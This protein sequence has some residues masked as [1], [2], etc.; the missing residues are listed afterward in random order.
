M[1]VLL[2]GIIYEEV[3]TLSTNSFVDCGRSHEEDQRREATSLIGH[4][5]ADELS[6]RCFLCDATAVVLNAVALGA[7]A[8][9]HQQQQQAP[10]AAK[11]AA[12]PEILTESISFAR[13]G[14]NIAGH[15]ARP[16]GEGP[17]R[18]VLVIGGDVGISDA[19]RHVCEQLAQSG[20]VGLAV[21][22]FSRFPEAK[23]LATGRKIF[24]E[25]MSDAQIL[26]DLEGAVAFARGRPFVRGGGVATLGYCMGGRYGLLLAARSAAVAATVSYYGLLKLDEKDRSKNHPDAPMD[27]LEH[28]ET[29][30]LLR[31]A[32]HDDGIPVEQVK[33]CEQTLAAQDTPVELFLYETGHGFADFSRP[34]YDARSAALAWE[35][36]VAFLRRYLS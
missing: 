8:R 20:F 3:R 24:A 7:A 28:I 34:C 25:K 27:V 6:R 12:P 21:D 36:T 23:D 15:L 2:A 29:P 11:G 18:L 16:K 5:E 10:P 35:R 31:Y 22:L 26:R 17:F 4:E 30:V 14:D 13:E 1:G 9:A 19:M 33:A 32:T